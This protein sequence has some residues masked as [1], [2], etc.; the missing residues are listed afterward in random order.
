VLGVAVTVRRLAAGTPPSRDRSIDLMRAL[1]IGLVVLGHWFVI[2]V[3]YR[4]GELSG[5]NAL[6]VLNWLHPSPGCSK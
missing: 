6:H 4:D 3:T 2:A 1:A 5:D